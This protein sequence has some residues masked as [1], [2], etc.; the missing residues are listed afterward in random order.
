MITR[1]VCSITLGFLVVL[2][3]SCT[4]YDH[5]SPD[6]QANRDG[7]RRHIGFAPSDAVSKLYYYAD[8]L[9][10]DVSYQLGFETDRKTIDAVVV[11][12]GLAQKQSDFDVGID[13]GTQQWF[14]EVRGALQVE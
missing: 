4:K 3:S 13:N 6:T 2:V 9:G 8:E 10:A 11:S 7:F 5:D 12:L 1:S 14:A